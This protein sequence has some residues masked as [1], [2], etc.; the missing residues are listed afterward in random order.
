MKAG[1][2]RKKIIVLVFVPFWSKNVA[3]FEHSNR[4]RKNPQIIF[5]LWIQYVCQNK[6][7][8]G[9]PS[10]SVFRTVLFFLIFYRR[11][12]KSIF[13]T[14]KAQGNRKISFQFFLQ[15]L[16][17]KDFWAFSGICANFSLQSLPIIQIQKMLVEKSS[18]VEISELSWILSKMSIF[19]RNIHVHMPF[20]YQNLESWTPPP[21]NYWTFNQS[22]DLH[23]L[24]KMFHK[25]RNS[26]FFKR[27]VC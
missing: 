22:I 18:G 12:L 7:E 26:H 24:Q 25:D 16:F 10:Q 20:L 21:N 15:K 2:R 9:Q 27:A 17:N 8:K 1:K 5:C 3:L 23:R 4:F 11:N 13:R 19:F 6:Q 14:F